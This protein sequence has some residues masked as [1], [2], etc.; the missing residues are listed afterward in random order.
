MRI[1]YRIFSKFEE[2]V[3][4]V[5]LQFRFETDLQEDIRRLVWVL[6][7]SCKFSNRDEL[8]INEEILLLQEC[9]TFVME[10]M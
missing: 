8:P 9:L 5:A 10:Q 7:C 2:I 1:S 6:F 3:K 4:T